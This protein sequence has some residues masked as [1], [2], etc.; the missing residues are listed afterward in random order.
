M[1]TQS[2]SGRT[3]TKQGQELVQA[4]GDEKSEH[5]KNV[6]LLWGAIS[7]TLIGIH[8]YIDRQVMMADQAAQFSL[9]DGVDLGPWM[10]RGLFD[11]DPTRRRA[12]NIIVLRHTHTHTLS[13]PVSRPDFQSSALFYSF[14]C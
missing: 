1:R 3:E 12:V 4:N 11:D 6:K 14:V 8:K 2:N 13:C 5:D 10:E 7:E 9:S